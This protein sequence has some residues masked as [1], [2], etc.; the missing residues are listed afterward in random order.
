MGFLCGRRTRNDKSKRFIA[1]REKRAGNAN[2][3]GLTDQQNVQIPAI[4]GREM[5]V[6][7]KRRQGRGVFNLTLAGCT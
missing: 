1:K 2:N 5:Y 6:R 3:N 7:K 4:N